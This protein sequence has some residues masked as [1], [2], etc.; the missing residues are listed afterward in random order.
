MFVAPGVLRTL[1]VSAC[2]ILRY[3]TSV[4]QI[5]VA[6]QSRLFGFFLLKREFFRIQSTV[7]AE[8]QSAFNSEKPKGATTLIREVL[9]SLILQARDHFIH[10][11][12]TLREEVI[13]AEDGRLINLKIKFLAQAQRR[14]SARED[15]THA[16]D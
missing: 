8:S 15:E 13:Y 4:I 16:G 7:S 10:E 6:M 1:D 12:T 9:I 11:L 3:D 5:V 14:C 2:Q